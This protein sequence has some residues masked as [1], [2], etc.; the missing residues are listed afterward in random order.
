MK[1][2]CQKSSE[3][4]N[5]TFIFGCVHGLCRQ[6]IRVRAEAKTLQKTENPQNTT[7]AKD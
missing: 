1:S 4:L 3:A 7:S 2:E 6:C 5:S